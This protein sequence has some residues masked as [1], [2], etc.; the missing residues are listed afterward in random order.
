M[1]NTFK[2]LVF[3]KMDGKQLKIWEEFKMYEKIFNEN[4]FEKNKVTNQL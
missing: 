1:I 4:Y 3:I 2:W